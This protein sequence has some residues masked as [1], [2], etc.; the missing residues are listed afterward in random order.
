MKK[1][2]HSKYYVYVGKIEGWYVEISGVGDIIFLQL[3]KKT[4]YSYIK[5]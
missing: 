4:L 2:N 5:S 1:V 3:V